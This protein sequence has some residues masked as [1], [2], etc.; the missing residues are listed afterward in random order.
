[1]SR[2]WLEVANQAVLAGLSRPIP[3]GNVQTLTV[4]GQALQKYGD[5]AGSRP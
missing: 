4:S 2:P 3:P 5:S 1:M